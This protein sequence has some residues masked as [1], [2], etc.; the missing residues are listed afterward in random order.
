[1]LFLELLAATICAVMYLR[2]KWSLPIWG[3]IA[4]L[5]LHFAFWDAVCFGPYFWRAPIESVVAIAG[6]C[7]A[8]VWGRYVSVQR[9][10]VDQPG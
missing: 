9:Q 2:A 1:L 7:S 4:L 5:V 6:L 8:L 10:Q 3:G